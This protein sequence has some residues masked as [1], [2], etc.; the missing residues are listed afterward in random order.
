MRRQRPQVRAGAAAEI[1]RPHRLRQ[2]P[3]EGGDEARVAGG[4]VGGLAQGEPVGAEAA[5]AVLGVGSLRAA[6][7]AAAV[8]GQSGRRRP[9]AQDAAAASARRAGSAMSARR[10]R[11][12]RGRR[13]A[14]PRGR[15]PR[16]RLGGR[17]A[18][19]GDE[20]QP[21]GEG[22]RERHAVALEQRGR[23]REVGLGI[24]PL[25]RPRRHRAGQ[26]DAGIE[27]GCGDLVAEGRGAIRCP[28]EAA[29]DRQRPVEV[30]ERR[31]RPHQDVVA[32][33][34]GDG[35]DREEPDRRAGPRHDP[36]G[37]GRAGLRDGDP[38]RRHAELGREQ[39]GG[40]AA[41]RHDAGRERQSP[42]LARD[43]RRR[44]LRRQ[45]GLVAERVMHQ[46]R[47]RA[48]GGADHLRRQGP[49][50]EAVDEERGVSRHLR[51]EGGGAGEVVRAWIRE[52][53]RQGE[54]RRRHPC[55][56]RCARSWRA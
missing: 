6:A 52:P 42:A 38:L 16:H 40:V 39:P 35:P 27:A 34:R 48:S 17:T 26:R 56:G 46:S 23:D 30:G 49:V 5:H 50:G 20:G 54:M 31:E 24:E 41:R 22:F 21:A 18:G 25:E 32:L 28:V 10:R 15:R 45:A 55:A 47:H 44:P 37:G 13:R 51:Q 1:D 33:A 29:G 9:A 19:G 14:A 43:Q 7:T 2:H 8:S 12:G 3:R 53:A 11:R 36:G 4:A